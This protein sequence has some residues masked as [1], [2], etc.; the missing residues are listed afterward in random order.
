MKTFWKFLVCFAT[1]TVVTPSFAAPPTP[2]DALECRDAPECIEKDPALCKDVCEEKKVAAPASGP[3][4]HILVCLDQNLATFDSTRDENGKKACVCPEGFVDSLYQKRLGKNYVSETR[5]CVVSDLQKLLDQLTALERSDDQVTKEDIADLQRQIDNLPPAV[6]PAEH[7][8]LSARVDRLGDRVTALEGEVVELDERV[9]GLEATSVDFEIQVGGAALAALHPGG[10]PGTFGA[11]GRFGLA[12]WF[13]S[14][15]GQ[16]F[17]LAGTAAY[18]MNSNDNRLMTAVELDFV[19]ALTRDRHHRL[20]LG[21][22]GLTEP[23][24]EGNLGSFFGGCGGYRF[25]NALSIGAGICAGGAVAPMYTEQGELTSVRTPGHFA[26]V[27][28]LDVSFAF[29][30]PSSSARRSTTTTSSSVT[31]GG[32]ASTD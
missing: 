3:I 1:I 26:L 16:A 28:K 21:V 30:G 12:G 4:K 17:Q 8:A 22:M 7:E 10:V 29:G 18:G 19:L 13:G 20:E 14:E 25:A 23:G 15:K 9:T 2:E 31:V 11:G 24:G 32:D 6:D 5:H 27:P